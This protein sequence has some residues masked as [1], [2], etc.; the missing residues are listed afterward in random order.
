[1]SHL[2]MSFKELGRKTLFEE[3]KA[4]RMALV[5]AARRLGLSYRQTCRSY[6]RFAADGDAGL[7][8]RSRGRPSNR[9]LAA[10]LRSKVLARYAERYEGFG[11]TLAAEKLAQDGLVVDHETLRRWLLQEGLFQR[12]RKGVVHRERRER[13]AHFGELVQMDGSIHEWFGLEHGYSCLMGMS[14]DATGHRVALL[15]HGETTELAMRALWLWIERHGI[16]QSLYTDKKSVYITDREPTLE[17]QLADE[18][19]KTAFGKACAKL[20]IEII[21]ANSPQAKGRIERSHGVFQD[22]FVKELALR[23]ITTI[24][25]ANKLLI[26]GFTDELNAKFDRE[27]AS[28]RDVHRPLPK[29][30]NLAD[31][32]CFEQ[33]RTVQNDWTLQYENEH[34]QIERDNRLLP[35]PKEKVVVRIR[36][37]KS[38][39]I[40]YKDKALKARKIPLS[41][42][43]ATKTDRD[44]EVIPFTTEPGGTH[45]GRVRTPWRQNCTLMLADTK[46][47]KR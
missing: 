32:F 37:D 39:E 8:H 30:L 46:K 29:G 33:T 1:M 13:K 31:V 15:D 23:R 5:E 45:K 17:E 28:A 24:K 36:L 11:P 14:D 7:V 25:G 43:R 26:N 42:L 6:R 9:A 21:T 34:Y 20:G 18:T 35:K 41:E 27:P 40:L 16:P 38:M 2:L 10:K 4:G 47:P 12:R 3:V 19:P 22:R 44:Q